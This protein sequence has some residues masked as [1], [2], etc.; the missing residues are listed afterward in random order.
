[1]RQLAAPTRS[2]ASRLA[3]TL[4]DGSPGSSS[5][6]SPQRSPH[7]VQ[8][9]GGLHV[10][11]AFSSTNGH[12]IT[13]AADAATAAGKRRRAAAEAAAAERLSRNAGTHSHNYASALS[14]EPASRAANGNV[15]TS[16]LFLQNSGVVEVDMAVNGTYDERA[17]VDDEAS[18]N[19]MQLAM[20]KAD[21]ET[22]A[23]SAEVEL[24]A[25]NERALAVQQ[26]RI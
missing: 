26:V 1:M 18:R 22:R 17:A 19:L 5:S 23:T 2:L 21:A 4:H 20:E 24:A 12:G 16:P 7:P 10:A 11:A 8:P 15:C 25:A 6:N 9:T 14:P 13:S 3:H